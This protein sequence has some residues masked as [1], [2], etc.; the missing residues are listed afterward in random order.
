MSIA[1]GKALYEVYGIILCRKKGRTIAKHSLQRD[2]DDGI[3]VELHEASKN[4][5]LL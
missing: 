4:C 2:D 5:T 1:I 3:N